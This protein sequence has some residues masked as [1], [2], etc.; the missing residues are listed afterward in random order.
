MVLF[1]NRKIR[2]V[3]DALRDKSLVFKRLLNMSIADSNADAVL[4]GSKLHLPP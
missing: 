1:R 2:K 3:V 4:D